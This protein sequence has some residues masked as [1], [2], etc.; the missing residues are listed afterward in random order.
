MIG[1]RY[2]EYSQEKTNL[3]FVFNNDLVR[4]PFNCSLEQNWHEDLE[5][6]QCVDGDGWVIVNGEKQRFSKGDVIVV[7]S[8]AIHYTGTDSRVVYSCAIIKSWFCNQIGII[9]LIVF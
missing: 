1:T 4:T 2:E 8:N 5:R 3:P 9:Y 6:Q 7:G